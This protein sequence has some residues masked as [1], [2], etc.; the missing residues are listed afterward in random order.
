MQE[1]YPQ[2]VTAC[3]LL[4]PCLSACFLTD[5]NSIS[6]LILGVDDHRCKIPPALKISHIPARQPL[7]QEEREA[8]ERRARSFAGGSLSL[9][10]VIEDRGPY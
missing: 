7:T 5:T 3:D 8:R 6:M 2:E 4:L 10:M 9:K 1:I